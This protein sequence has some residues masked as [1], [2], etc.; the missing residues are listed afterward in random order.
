MANAKIEL[1]SASKTYVIQGLLNLTIRKSQ[2]TPPL[3]IP[4]LDDKKAVLSTAMGQVLT[5][6]ADFIILERTDDYTNGTGSP[7][8][9]PYSIDDQK[10]YL[11]DTIFAT[12]GQH[13]ITDVDGNSFTG[14]IQDMEFVTKGDD[15]LSDSCVFTF[16]RGI[17]L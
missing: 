3:P 8:G 15:P 6:T 17:T 5:I 13:R 11:R 7:S 2:Q 14:R 4:T 9:P 16:A 10:N 12:S 1:V